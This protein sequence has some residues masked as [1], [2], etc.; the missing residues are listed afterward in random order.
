MIHKVYTF[1]IY[2]N[3]AQSILI[4]KMMLYSIRFFPF[5]MGARIGKGKDLI[6]GQ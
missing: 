3:Q 5:P 6:L 4:N 2:P 1:R